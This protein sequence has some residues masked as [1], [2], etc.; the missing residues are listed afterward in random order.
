MDHTDLPLFR[1]LTQDYELGTDTIDIPPSEAPLRR[2]LRYE[3]RNIAFA[4]VRDQSPLS[5]DCFREFDVARQVMS[6][7]LLAGFYF[8]AFQYPQI[9]SKKVPDCGRVTAF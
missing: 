2:R 4:R 1:A 5:A 9:P 7:I 6:Q 3:P 8:A